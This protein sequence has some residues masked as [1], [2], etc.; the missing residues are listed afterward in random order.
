MNT[1]FDLAKRPF[2]LFTIFISLS[3]AAN[4]QPDIRSYVEQ[5]AIPISSIHP[6]STNF[7]DLEYIGQSIGDAKVVM[8]GEEDHGDAAAFLAKTR[9]IKYLHEKKGFNVLAFEAEFFGMND[10]ARD[11][12]KKANWDDLINN[13]IGFQWAGCDGCF[14]LF[15]QYLPSTLSSPSPLFVTGVD[16]LSN[17][18]KLVARL[19]S[20]AKAIHLP[21]TNTREYK[22]SLFPLIQTWYNYTKD[23]L[24]NKRIQDG[25]TVIKSQMLQKL[26]KDDFWIKTLENLITLNRMYS[27]VGKDYWKERNLRDAQMAENLKWLN[28]E[29]YRNEKIIVWAHNY[30]VSKYSGHFTNTYL[31]PAV[32]MGTVFTADAGVLNRTYIIGFTARQGRT[33]ALGKEQYNIRKPDRNSL[34]NWVNYRGL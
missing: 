20:I 7:T 18:K 23:T 28:E 17:S 32:T 1:F 10:P 14:P 6:D 34:E 4:A 8:L 16:V 3:I 9:L 19:D 25:L 22:E 13:Y 15:H 31:N 21:I 5:N 27:P 33:G 29:K 2:Q 26:D 30:H 12:S 24:N 11:V